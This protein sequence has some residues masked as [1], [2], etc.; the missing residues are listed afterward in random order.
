MSFDKRE[1]IEMHC[2]NLVS[3]NEIEQPHLR[4]KPFEFKV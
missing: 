1:E 4:V 3:P 2:V